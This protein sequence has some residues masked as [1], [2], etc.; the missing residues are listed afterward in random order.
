MTRRTHLA[1]YRATHVLYPRAFRD[2]YGEALGAVFEQQLD[3]LGAPRCWLRTLRDLIV[4]IPS[5]QLESR[6]NRPSSSHLFVFFFA[7]GTGAALM[8]AMIGTSM[9]AAVV[10][11][12]AVA[13]FGVAIA[14]RRAAKPAITLER[15][16][17]W[18]K[19]LVGG[20]LMLGTLIIM[21]NLPANKDQD[22]STIEWS[23][24]ML[25]IL[26]SLSLIGAG[27]VLG[28]L[29]LHRKRHP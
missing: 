24:L 19:F 25:S 1:L 20:G 15:T 29:R 27:A 5:Q 12:V 13:S 22:L 23:V 3:E 10:A 18:K 26:I 4:S 6:M 7:L 9:Y 2:E 16:S 11:L 8:T 28:A 21:M 17:S 14:L